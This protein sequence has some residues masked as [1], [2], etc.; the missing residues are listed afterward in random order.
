MSVKSKI[1]FSILNTKISA[2]YLSLIIL[3]QF[4]YCKYQFKNFLFIF[5][6]F[7]VSYYIIPN[8]MD[9]LPADYNLGSQSSDP[10]GKVMLASFNQKCTTFATATSTAYYMYE[11][12]NFNKNSLVSSTY[13]G[14]YTGLCIFESYFSTSLVAF[15]SS[16]SPRK[17]TVLNVKKGN[18]ICNLDFS[19]SVLSVKFSK[20]HLAVVIEHSILIYS[21]AEMKLLFSIDNIP[22]NRQGLCCLSLNNDSL[23]LAYP[24]SSTSGIIQL[25]DISES[26][27]TNLIVAHA[28]ALAAMEFDPTA[29]MIATT[30]VK[31]TVI[32]V[33]SV[34]D[35]QKLF[36]FRRGTVR[37]VSVGTLAFSQDSSLLLVSSNTKTVHI[38]KLDNANSTT[39]HQSKELT[40]AN[41]NNFYSPWTQWAS[42][43]APAVVPDILS[44][45]RDFATIK[46]PFANKKNVCAFT[47]VN[48]VL[49]VAVIDET[50]SLYL[51]GLPKEGGE[52]TACSKYTLC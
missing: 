24:A 31:G 36:Q 13:T 49:H 50:G 9:A 34:P 52:C 38:F 8:V 21:V 48:E 25:Y 39:S 35:G 40:E 1:L 26:S 45:E 5:T 32:R 3:K 6:R 46:L 12:K 44:Q 15:V 29:K 23:Y 11:V 2:K 16:S 27:N 14:N 7:L 28:S 41:S 22:Q 37:Y 43:F 19:D 30:S 42:S 18:E 51:Y 47:T 17:L 33:F 20:L 10:R 4:I